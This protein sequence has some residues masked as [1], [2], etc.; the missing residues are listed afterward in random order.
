MDHAAED[1]SSHPFVSVVVP[2]ANRPAVLADCVGSLIAQDYPAFEVV[3][4]DN[5]ST[6]SPLS[7]HPLVR[8]LRLERRDANSARNAGIEASRGDPICLVDDDVVAPP[9]W[10]SG[11]VDGVRRNPTADCLGGGIRARFESQPP[12]TCSQHDLAGQS[13]DRG[14]DDLEATEVWGGNMAIR[15]SAFESVG[16]FKPGLRR[17]QDWEWE[18]RLLKM[19]GRMV[20][21][22]DAWLWHRRG[23]RDL[24]VPTLLSEFFL[25][26]YTRAS[27]GFKVDPE[28]T[29]RRALEN[30]R[31]GVR[32][33]CVRG[34]EEAARDA[35]LLCAALLRR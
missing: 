15:R 13:L 10:L 17:H 14:P 7:P 6:A 32:E 24:R 18:Q 12:R 29:R 21:V 27:L 9:S 8:C 16:P 23:R 26:G 5:G 31:H 3:V 19:G 30:L 2:T 1:S 33:R 22:G 34:L 25:R 11:L 20:Y 28:R 35:G 4:V